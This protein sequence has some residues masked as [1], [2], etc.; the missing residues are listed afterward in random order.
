MVVAQAGMGVWT[1]WSN[2]AADVATGHVVLGAACLALS[3][4]L[5]LAAKRCE[6]IADRADEAKRSHSAAIDSGQAA[7]MAI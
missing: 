2:K 3:S 5:L 6:F 7:A 1:I 4:L